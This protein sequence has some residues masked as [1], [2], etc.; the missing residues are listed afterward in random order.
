[1]SQPIAA[2]AADALEPSIAHETESWARPFPNDAVNK[3]W[4]DFRDGAE[5]L[6]F[7]TDTT[8]PSASDVMGAALGRL[9]MGLASIHMFIGDSSKKVKRQV[10]RAVAEVN[11]AC[12]DICA[13]AATPDGAAAALSTSVIDSLL[14]ALAYIHP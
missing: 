5:S 9:S 11:A 13:A 4:T 14:M 2:L 3:A 10:D 6:P 1:M 12:F 8:L 7:E